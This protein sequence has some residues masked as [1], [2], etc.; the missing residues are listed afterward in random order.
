MMAMKSSLIALLAFA[1][2]ASS[3]IG[4]PNREFEPLDI[5]HV[6]RVHVDEVNPGWSTSKSVRTVAQWLPRTFW[7]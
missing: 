5:H 3:A 6:E 7:R 2:V 1:S 4:Q